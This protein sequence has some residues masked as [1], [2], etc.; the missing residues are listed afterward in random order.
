M[1]LLLRQLSTSFRESFE[2]F[3]TDLPIADFFLHHG[4][5]ARTAITGGAVLEIKIMAAASAD[6]QTSNHNREG[7]V[8]VVAL[9]F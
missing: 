4:F 5:V 3:L 2:L 1:F 8:H 9:Q 7:P 6:D